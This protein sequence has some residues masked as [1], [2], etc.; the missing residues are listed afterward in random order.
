MSPSNAPAVGYAERNSAREVER[1]R[2]KKPAVHRP[3]ITEVDP[4]EGKARLIDV[5]SA[6]QE[7]RMANARPSIDNGEKFR[8]SSC[9]IPKAARWSSSATR[10]LRL[11]AMTLTLLFVVK[12]SK[13]KSRSA[14]ITHGEERDQFLSSRVA[15]LGAVGE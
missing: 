15:F 7:L 10:S 2:L 5:E 9:W 4:P 14:F 3:Q 6:V 13:S 12:V 11:V 8:F 1:H